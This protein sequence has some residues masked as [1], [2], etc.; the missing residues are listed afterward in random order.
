MAEMEIKSGD[1]GQ[2]AK[3]DSNKRLHT[4]TISETEAS[5]AADSLIGEKYNINTGDITLTDANPTDILF[6]KNT[7]ANDLVITS[8]IYNMGNSNSAAAVNAKWEIIR[9]PTTGDIIT[10]ANNVA[11][12]PGVSANQNFGSNN[13]ITGLFYKGA[14]SEGIVSDGSVTISSRLA[15]NTGRVVISL[16]SLVLPKGTSLVAQYT[17]PAGNT[18]QIVQCAAACYVRTTKVSD[19]NGG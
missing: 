13:I 12:G 6:V 14:T 16:G 3:V 19:N 5:H 15:N 17:P 18:S 11:V 2:V 7:G 1:S 9:N 10:N 8:I 4:A